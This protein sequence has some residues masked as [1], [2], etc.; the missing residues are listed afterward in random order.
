[1]S[2]RKKLPIPRSGCSLTLVDGKVYI[3]G[4][5]VGKKVPVS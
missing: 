1:M 4:G 2:C 3:Y 5:Q